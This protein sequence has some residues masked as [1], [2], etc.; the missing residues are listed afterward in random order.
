MN[1]FVKFLPI[2]LKKNFHGNENFNKKLF[3]L[4]YSVDLEKKYRNRVTILIEERFL[5]KLIFHRNFLFEER[6]KILTKQFFQKSIQVGKNSIMP[7]GREYLVTSR[8][9][10]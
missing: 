2:F 1:C 3:L 7:S 9:F 5:P 6:E 10:F 4:K 8:K